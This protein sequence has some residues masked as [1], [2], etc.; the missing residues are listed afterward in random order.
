MWLQK[1]DLWRIH[2]DK[3][4]IIVGELTTYTLDY[5]E[6]HPMSSRDR[7]T[8]EDMASRLIN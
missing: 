4:L 3:A 2:R 5:T 7:E 8:R 6:D 1:P